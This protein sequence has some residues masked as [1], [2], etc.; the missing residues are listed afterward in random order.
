MGE[1]S[2]HPSQRIREG[3]VDQDQESC[4]IYEQDQRMT[5]VVYDVT[6]FVLKAENCVQIVS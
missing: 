4:E 1:A 2:P 6:T 5:R 3:S